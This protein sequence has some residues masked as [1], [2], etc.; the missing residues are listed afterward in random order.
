[1]NMPTTLRIFAILLMISSSGLLI[2]GIMNKTPMI[3]TAM[4]LLLV[5]IALSVVARKREGK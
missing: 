2:W 4:P 5:G 3:T 1:M